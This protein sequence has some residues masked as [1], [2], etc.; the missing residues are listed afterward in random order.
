VLGCK[1]N[2]YE[3]QQIR[4]RL[5]LIGL[6][7][8]RPG[9]AADLAVVH[10]CAVTSQAVRK[11]RQV[12]RR[13]QQLHPDARVVITGCAAS[14]SLME[15][16]ASEA[17]RM[18]P[19]EDWLTSVGALAADLTPPISRPDPPPAAQLGLSRFHG[20]ARAFLKVQDGCDIGCS[21][22]IVPRLRRAPRDKPAAEVVAEA[23][24]MVRAGHREIVVAGVSVGLYGRRG[25][26]GSLSGILRDVLDIPGLR[27]VRV[28]SLHP[29]ELSDELLEVWASS[30]KM[31]PHV[32][33]PLQSGSDAVL[34]DMNRG[35][36][37]DQ[38]LDAV[39]RARRALDRPAF[40]T[41]V[42]VGFPGETEE[43]F[44]DTLRVAKAAGFARMHVFPYSPRPHTR[45]GRRRRDRIPSQTIRRR[46]SILGAVSAEM[47]TDYHRQFQ[48]QTA[49]VLVE[50][51]DAGTGWCS[52]HSERYLQ[53]QC[54]APAAE[55]GGLAR[56][57]IDR[58]GAG[59]A[60]ATY[61]GLAE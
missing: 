9:Q 24:A 31:M 20:Q 22:C 59:E 18:A 34:A 19:R 37:A 26:P 32:H 41:D 30:P 8:A 61:Q 12:M 55:R 25:G 44:G 11:S 57:R 39:D 1:V 50:S 27:R 42:I 58:V 17:D 6:E 28:S 38:F 23:K 14:E 16:L 21:F 13:L 54:C 33:L 47:A 10:S 52:G 49:V 53:I 56:V 3:A 15:D 45:A 7:P 48:G 29:C 43:A 60:T 2:Q 35:Y 46:C 5:Q 4:R 36:N 40:N 51:K